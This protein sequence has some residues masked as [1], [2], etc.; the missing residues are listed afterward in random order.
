[1]K[2]IIQNYTKFSPFTNEEAWLL[3][4]LA[5]WGEAIGWT[6]LISGAICQRV[7]HNDIPVLITGQ[8]HGLLFLMYIAA[9]LV[10]SPSLKWRGHRTLIAGL[11]AVPPYGSLLF[12]VWAA[13]DRRREHSDFLRYS[14]F[15]RRLLQAD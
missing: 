9:V 7:I 6:L 12:E 8:I 1:M 5:A 15:Y 10:L 14:I 4:K 13:Y 2:R 3:F 11:C